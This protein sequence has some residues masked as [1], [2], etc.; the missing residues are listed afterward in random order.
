[1][2]QAKGRASAK[3]LGREEGGDLVKRTEV[4]EGEQ[5]VEGGPET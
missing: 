5:A 3:A 4:S 1:M 2:S